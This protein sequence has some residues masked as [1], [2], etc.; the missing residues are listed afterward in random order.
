MKKPQLRGE[1]R[2]RALEDGTA[3]YC[4]CGGD[5]PS[6]PDYSGL[7]AANEK[8]TQIMADQ[9][10]RTLE[11]TKGQYADVRPYIFNQLRLGAKGAET[12]NRVADKNA[13]A[14]TEGVT[15]GRTSFRPTELQ[16][17]KDAYGYSWLSEGE[18]QKFDEAMAGNSE[19]AIER[20]RRDRIDRLTQDR[21]AYDR[22]RADYEAAVKGAKIDRQAIEDELRPT[23]MFGGGAG[24]EI[25]GYRPPTLNETLQGSGSINAD[26]MVPIYG[27]ASGP[28]LDEAGLNQAVEN[29]VAQLM[30]EQS[31]V[32]RPVNR[33]FDAELSAINREFDNQ[34]SANDADLEMAG[35]QRRAMKTA[36]EGAA[37][38]ASEAVASSAAQSREQ[39]R[40][41]LIE[42]G[43]N[44][45]SPKFAAASAATDANVV[46]Q[47]A[48]AENNARTT[49]KDKN[50]ALRAGTANF[51]RNMPNTAS[52]AYQVAVGASSA[53]PNTAGVGVGGVMQGT[54]MVN[55]AAGNVLQAQSTG[56]NARLGLA[57]LQNSAYQAGLASSAQESAGL[58]SLLGLGLRYGMGSMTGGA[59]LAV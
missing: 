1:R 25:V 57:G 47:Q 41:A 43:I 23:F 45:N 14:A 56:I 20:D 7:A 3:G 49:I 30:K 18:Q 36:E 38:Q 44:P 33:D 54:G 12:Q 50:V 37:K 13:E 22:Q 29:R 2:I 46:A 21:A 10:D 8:A 32:E 51:G 6:P 17:I 5:A 40:R 27:E 24:G 48:A 52:N 28:R 26:G 4:F 15:Y 16:T 9:A 53:S 58:G 19:S 31:G 35:V 11:F 42:L 34:R 59:G 55:Q 39:G